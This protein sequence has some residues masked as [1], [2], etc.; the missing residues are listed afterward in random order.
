M[1]ERA[2][3]RNTVGAIVEAVREQLGS[4]QLRDAVVGAAQQVP[5]DGDAAQRVSAAMAPVTAAQASSGARHGQPVP[6]LSRNPIVSLVQSSIEDTLLARGTPSAHP[7]HRGFFGSVLHFLEEL[8]EQRKFGPDD[9]DWV[10]DVAAAM[11]GHLAKGNHPFN[12]QPA[13]HEI[14]DTARVVVVGD[15]GTGL[16]GAQDV[17]KHMAQEV[18]DALANGREAHVVHLGDIYYSGLPS[19]IERRV[20]PY[21]PVT[22][23]QGQGGVTSW[24]LN[25]NHDMYSGG[26]GYFETLLADP[27]FS[28]QH[29]A[30]GKPTS[31]FGL[32]APSWELVGLD[33]SWSSAV[34]TEGAVAVLEQPQAQFVASVAQESD[35][36]LVLLSHHQLVSTY[37]P[38]DI[39]P[40]LG[41][42]LAPVLG[43]GRVTA[44]FWGHE[45][46]CM[47]F[48]A[49]GGV[50]F[51]R[52]IGHGGVPVLQNYTAGDPVKAPGKWV[53]PGYTESGGDRW[54]RFGFAVLDLGPDQI[55]VR[56]RNDDGTET[57]PA[58]VIA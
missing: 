6:F 16:S 54:A 33:T 10:T 45:H 8:A 50:K 28:A 3:D 49:T 19:E 11:L 53:A 2:F 56:Y 39:G 15:W 14:A 21:W 24:S 29:S 26:Y 47:G 57:V 27:R 7:E 31:F 44:W 5:G 20:L 48:E 32:T 43:D 18:A 36:K 42:D 58:E 4:A 37:D 34:L 30:D 25:G 35:R 12:P 17:A 52:C 9:I 13:R 41:A 40:A 46:R 55:N 1:I 38:E 51:P 22:A 23:E